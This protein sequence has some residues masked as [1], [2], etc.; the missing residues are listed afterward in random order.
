MIAIID[1]LCYNF[2]EPTDRSVG[3]YIQGE[4]NEQL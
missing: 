3:N 1:K 2:K 4:S